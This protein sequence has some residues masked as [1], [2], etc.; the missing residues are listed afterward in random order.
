[1]IAVLLPD[2][3]TE[4]ST[5]LRILICA[6]FA[7]ALGIGLGF[8]RTAS[9]FGWTVGVPALAGTERATAPSAHPRLVI[10]AD[11]YAFGRMK[12]NATGTHTFI[13]RNEGLENLKITPGKPSCK[14]TVS[15]VSRKVIPPGETAEVT[16][17]WKTGKSKGK[18]RKRAPISTNDPTQPKVQLKIEGTVTPAF[19]FRPPTLFASSLATDTERTLE[20]ELFFYNDQ[21]VQLLEQTLSDDSLAPRFAIDYIP[22]AED[23]LEEPYATCGYRIR[24]TI[25]P[26]MEVGNFHQSVIF[27]TEPE[28]VQPVRLNINGSVRQPVNIFGPHLDKATQ[29]FDMG[30]LKEG[31]S[32]QMRLLLQA[33]G[34]HREEIAPRLIRSE[35]PGIELNVGKSR[36]LA[37]GTLSQ[38][39]LI[40]SLPKQIAPGVYGPSSDHPGQLVIATGHPDYPEITLHVKLHVEPGGEKT[41]RDTA[42]EPS[43]SPAEALRTEKPIK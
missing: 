41:D 29:T 4:K 22:V 7:A 32:K 10:S 12:Q 42:T 11:T 38:F 9:E 18:Y 8:L 35:P 43:R 3:Q 2:Y 36:L 16:L 25:L 5:V 31:Q 13:L 26:G 37:K 21:N 17:T 20:A 34:E 14:C 28:M 19:A 24:V 23:A 30:T 1:M 33:A 15:K 27:R 39:S 40:F 6:I